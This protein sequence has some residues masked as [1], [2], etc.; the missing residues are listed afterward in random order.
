M[1]GLASST[2]R[3][4]DAELKM[5]VTL[6]EGGGWNTQAVTDTFSSFCALGGGHGLH[7]TMCLALFPLQHPQWQ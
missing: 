6:D 2:T 1:T 7:L 4:S 3:G 5:F